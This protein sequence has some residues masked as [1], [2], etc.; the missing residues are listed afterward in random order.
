MMIL[1]PAEPDLSL[2]GHYSLPLAPHSRGS[3]KCFAWTVQYY[4]APNNALLAS[5]LTVQCPAPL[6]LF[7]TLQSV[8]KEEESITFIRT[9]SSF[10][11][12]SLNF[13]FFWQR[14]YRFLT[15]LF[16]SFSSFIYNYSPLFYWY[17]TS[18][19]EVCFSLI[20]KIVLQ[21][22]D[23]WSNFGHKVSI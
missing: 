21:Q 18:Y 10:Q 22:L 14:D 20:V 16:F 1:P 13:L 3:P 2:L 11:L 4:L 8:K 15:P 6:I 23:F 17:F 5:P 19:R 12:L 7:L 9:N